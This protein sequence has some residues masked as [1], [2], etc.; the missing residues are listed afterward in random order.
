[1]CMGMYIVD[2]LA[3]KTAF[4][5]GLYYFLQQPPLLSWLGDF[6]RRTE[7]VSKHAFTRGSSTAGGCSRDH[8]QQSASTCCHSSRKRQS[9]TLVVDERHRCQP[10]TSPSVC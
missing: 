7:G 9:Q 8:R 6:H 5:L 10:R 1:I 4:L 2:F 3:S